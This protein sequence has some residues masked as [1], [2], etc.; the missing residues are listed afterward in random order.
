MSGGGG[1]GSRGEGN[2]FGK[3]E[4]KCGKNKKTTK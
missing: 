4:V 3:M 1:G 2:G